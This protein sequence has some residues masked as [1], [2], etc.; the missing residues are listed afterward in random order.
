MKGRH[1]ITVIEAEI[2]QLLL[3]IKKNRDD[4]LNEKFPNDFDKSNENSGRNKLE[5]ALKGF[6][7]AHIAVNKSCWKFHSFPEDTEEK[8]AALIKFVEDQAEYDRSL[9][10]LSATNNE[11]DQELVVNF[12]EYYN[13]SK[14]KKTFERL[15]VLNTNLA[16]LELEEIHSGNKRREEQSHI[17]KTQDSFKE[18]KK[19]IK[20]ELEKFCTQTKEKRKE[21]L[22]RLKGEEK[23]DEPGTLESDLEKYESSYLKV[24]ELFYSKKYANLQGGYDRA[25]KQCNDYL[26]QLKMYPELSRDIQ[27]HI[28]YFHDFCNQLRHL[29]E[30]LAISTYGKSAISTPASGSIPRQETNNI[31]PLVKSSADSV[32][33]DLCNLSDDTVQVF[34]QKNNLVCTKDSHNSY[35]FYSSHNTTREIMTCHPQANRIDLIIPDGDTINKLFALLSEGHV[36]K[37]DIRQVQDP[38]VRKKI[39]T[40]AASNGITVEG[41]LKQEELASYQAVVQ[42]QHK[43]LLTTDRTELGKTTSTIPCWMGETDP[44]DSRD[45]DGMGE[46]DPKDSVNLDSNVSSQYF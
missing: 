36:Q 41:I 32:N 29:F 34:S 14:N 9:W 12:R 26:G 30:N 11:S 7:D 42:A 22:T 24:L 43:T 8:H 40:T 44:K 21:F 46:T 19:E 38:T 23:L 20:S 17:S 31:K 37:I 33:A 2:N 5:K 27:E 15:T 18:R 10:P 4:F 3:N 35:H 45:L 6:D 1:E 16:E 13:S 25:L 39:W 28:N